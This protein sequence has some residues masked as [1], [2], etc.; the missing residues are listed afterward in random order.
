MGEDDPMNI[1][2]VFDWL[3]RDSAYATEH[4][5]GPRQRDIWIKLAELWKAA[6]L[7]EE[8]RQERRSLVPQNLGETFMKR[9]GDDLTQDPASSD[10]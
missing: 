2:R 7:A 9:T 8:T 3:A 5:D 6:A 1:V 4:T 10:T